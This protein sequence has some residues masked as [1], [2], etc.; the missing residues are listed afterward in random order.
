MSARY[1]PP[2]ARPQPLAP[3]EAVGVGHTEQASSQVWS[4]HCTSGGPPHSVAVSESNKVSVDVLQS[5]GEQTGHVLPHDPT[6]SEGCDELGHRGPEPPVV[7]GTEAFPGEAGGLAGESAGDDVDVRAWFGLPPVER[8]A[9]IVMVGHLRPV[10][11]QHLLAERV[12]LDLSDDG[13]PGPL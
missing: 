7:V 13:H 6:G 10:R 12:D 2:V 1:R 5:S 11:G 3:M 9:D 8:G 4:T